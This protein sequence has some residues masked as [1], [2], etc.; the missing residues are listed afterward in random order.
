MKQTLVRPKVI[1]LSLLLSVILSTGLHLWLKTNSLAGFRLFEAIHFIEYR[2]NDLFHFSYMAVDENLDEV[3]QEYDLS[4]IVRFIND[5]W[6]YRD[7]FRFWDVANPPVQSFLA[8]GGDCDDYARLIAHILHVKGKSLVYYVMMV[9]EK[10][11]HAVAVYYDLD[12]K[13][14]NVIDV[15]GL[16]VGLSLENFDEEVHVPL[17]I[18]LIFAD[19][20]H[21]DVRTWDT[22]KSIVMKTVKEISTDEIN[23]R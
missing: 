2:I 3:I 16:W 1:L 9:S 23:F 21:V 14:L 20:V 8:N 11:G 18:K 4:T 7:D 17:V 5:Q 13:T 10:T 6:E 15:S 12:E 19:V 22:K